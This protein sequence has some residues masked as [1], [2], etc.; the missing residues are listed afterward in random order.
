VRLVPKVVTF[1]VLVWTVASVV[2]VRYGGP[3]LW[4]Q[5][6]A[7]REPSAAAV[8]SSEEGS[9]VTV[10]G[11]PQHNSLYVDGEPKAA[12]SRYLFHVE[13][14]PDGLLVLTDNHQTPEL[15]AEE[16]RRVGEP[17]QERLAREFFSREQTFTGVLVRPEE[18]VMDDPGGYVKYGG[19]YL[20]VTGK[21][22]HCEKTGRCGTNPMVLRVGEKP[23][24]RP[25]QVSIFAVLGA[26]PIVLALIALRARRR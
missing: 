20:K 4:P 1:G 23:L 3:L 24:G 9:W 5:D 14:W 26:V 22:S 19:E 10:R 2:T 18:Q 7:P 17:G 21:F 16:L 15:R 12:T 13:G 8:L 25:L 6:P 11:L